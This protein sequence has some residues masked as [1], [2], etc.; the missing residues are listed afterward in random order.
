MSV[1]CQHIWFNVTT[2]TRSVIVVYISYCMIQVCWNIEYADCNAI[3]EFIQANL[4][5]SQIQ[6]RCWHLPK[7]GNLESKIWISFRS[8]CRVKEFSFKSRFTSI[9]WDLRQMTGR[10][11]LLT[12][13][14]PGVNSI[15]R[16]MFANIHP[17]RLFSYQIY[18]VIFYMP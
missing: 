8:L 9:T 17:L 6:R 10:H 13:S 2:L 15:C 14:H 1:I 3:L 16:A 12:K 11:Q 4:E 18:G 7:N 5:T